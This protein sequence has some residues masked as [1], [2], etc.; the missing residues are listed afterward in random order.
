METIRHFFDT[1]KKLFSSRD[2]HAVVEEFLGSVQDTIS[3]TA[4][5]EETET[6]LSNDILDILPSVEVEGGKEEVL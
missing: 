4:L 1:V 5:G 6:A 2:N 3:S